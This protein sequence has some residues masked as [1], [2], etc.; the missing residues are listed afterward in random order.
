MTWDGKV[1]PVAATTPV[2]TNGSGIAA[3]THGLGFTPRVVFA[4]VLGTTTLAADAVTYT[5]TQFSVYVTVRS[6]GAAVPSTALTIEWVA[7]P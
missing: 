5:G 7:W 3:V 4:K 1:S 2:T 6:S